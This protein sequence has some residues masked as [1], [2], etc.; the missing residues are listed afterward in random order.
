[1]IQILSIAL[2]CLLAAIAWPA[3][4]GVVVTD[5]KFSV[6]AAGKTEKTGG[7]VIKTEGGK[8]RT[9]MTQLLTVDGKTQPSSAVTIAD[10]TTGK[11]Y[12][13]DEATKTYAEMDVSAMSGFA[14]MAQDP[15]FA[16]KPTGR[17]KTVAGHS[18][19]EFQSTPMQQMTT[20]SCYSTSAP[21][22]AEYAALAEK[23]LA[24]LT[25][26]G[27]DAQKLAAN[28]P[29]GILLWEETTTRPPD[30]AAAY[31][32][33]GLSDAQIKE[34]LKDAPPAGPTTSRTVVTSIKTQAIPAGEFEI[35]KGYTKAKSPF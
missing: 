9:V 11:I 1:M 21:G 29:K 4:A 18:C 23:S 6:D 28:S 19:D 15:N 20:L 10:Y 5:E 25:K 35:P 12:L 31:K 32:G 26:T 24:A 16:F 33:M 2:A 7:S 22:A 14:A 30:M 8:Q 17:K 3:T 27:V 34:I 13:L